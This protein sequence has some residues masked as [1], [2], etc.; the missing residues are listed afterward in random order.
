MAQ[1][2]GGVV[3]KVLLRSDKSIQHLRKCHSAALRIAFQGK[4]AEA[5]SLYERSQAIRE[6]VLGREHPDVAQSLNT[7]A[8]LLSAQVRAVRMFQEIACGTR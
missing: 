8:G 3:E 5:E 1:Q 2:Q 4:C 6:T 7:R